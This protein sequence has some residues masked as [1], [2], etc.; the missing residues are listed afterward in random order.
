MQ[1]RRNWAGRVGTRPCPESD[2][3]LTLSTL[4]VSPSMVPERVT[5]WPAWATTLSWLEIWYTLPSAT[6]T[7]G[8]PPLIQR[9]AHAAWS[10]AAPLSSFLPAHAASTM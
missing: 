10:S 8:D 5:L 3:I 2:Y 6:K 1:E 9:A 4:M 7:A